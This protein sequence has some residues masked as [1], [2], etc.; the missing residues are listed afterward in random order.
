M[1]NDDYP[2]IARE[3]TCQWDSSKVVAEIS[4]WGKV[5]PTWNSIA[6]KLQQQPLEVG[7][8]LGDRFMSFD[9]IAILQPDDTSMCGNGGHTISVVGYDPSPTSETVTVL[10]GR[11]LRGKAKR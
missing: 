8:F 7:F 5:Y 1:S 2:Y 11:R 4:G 3:T 10:Y 9:G 6:S